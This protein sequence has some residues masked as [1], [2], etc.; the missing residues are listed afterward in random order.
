MRT[1][2][3]FTVLPVI[4]FFSFL[5][6]IVYHLGIMQWIVEK[7]GWFLQVVLGTTAC[8]SVTTAANV[9]VGPAAANFMVRP[10]LVDMTVS[11]LHAVMTAGF[12][13]IAGE[14][15]VA[16]VSFGISAT[17]LLS[18]S[19]MSAPAALACSKLM[20]PGN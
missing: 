15:L 7:F 20:M 12:S 11:E 18:A 16:Y 14:V 19:F 17:H 13:T 6:A 10:Y 5:I 2:F 3:Y 9:F 8:E 4:I 1:S